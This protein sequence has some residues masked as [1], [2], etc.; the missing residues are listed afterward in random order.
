MYFDGP[1]IAA[2]AVGTCFFHIG[3]SIYTNYWMSRWVEHAD[4]SGSSAS[5]Y[6][7]ADIGLSFHTEAVDGV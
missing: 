5:C 7:V 1:F 4:A 3:A 6:L 2:L